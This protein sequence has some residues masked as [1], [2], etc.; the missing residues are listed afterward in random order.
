MDLTPA[1]DRFL[2]QG[3]ASGWAEATVDNY[4]HLLGQ[5]ADE[6]HRAGCRRWPDVTPDDLDAVMEGL[7]ERGVAKKS[8]VQVVTL[9]RRFCVWLRDQ[10]L[11][12]RNPAVALPQPD[13][14]EHDL[15]PPPLSEAEVAAIIDGIPRT[16]VYGLRNVCL[17]ELLYSCGL[18]ISEALA[19]DLD[20]VDLDRRTVLILESKHSQTRLVPLPKTARAAVEDYLALRRTLLRGPDRG[21]LFLTQYGRR[22]KRAS[23]YGWL[24]RLNEERGPE[25]RHLHPHLFRHS[26]AVHLLRGGADVRYIQ[27]FLGHASLDTTKIYLRLVPG[28]L[29]DDYDAAMPWLGVG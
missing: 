23:V 27:A 7:L 10:G 12:L 15:L 26:I 6:L 1:I 3:R 29:R 19:L 9:L 13:D 8:R 5:A 17:L 14:G 16:S 20:H 4:R 21:E 2:V 24:E 28:Q 11:V 22:W 18:R 25:Q